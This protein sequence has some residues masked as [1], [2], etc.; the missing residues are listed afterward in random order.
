MQWTSGWA[1]TLDPRACFLSESDADLASYVGT[2]KTSE[3]YVRLNMCSFP[4]TWT[5]D[6]LAPF[7][8]LVQL[9]ICVSWKG[10]LQ[11]RLGGNPSFNCFIQ[12]FQDNANMLVSRTC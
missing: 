10:P 8:K 11:T 2:S 4:E 7:D 5:H 3:I 6:Q 12:G 1:L 9:L